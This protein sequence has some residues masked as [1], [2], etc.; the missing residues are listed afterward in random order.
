MQ[1]CVIF[2]HLVRTTWTELQVWKHLIVTGTAF[3]ELKGSF[4]LLSVFPPRSMD[5]EMCQVS[6]L[7]YEKVG[8]S[9][10]ADVSNH[11]GQK[12]NGLQL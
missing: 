7:T 1:Q 5:T 10:Q 8:L 3:E 9:L 12:Q 6:A 4:S 2:V 11:N